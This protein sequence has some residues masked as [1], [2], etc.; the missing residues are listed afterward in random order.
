M[1]KR[2]IPGASDAGVYNPDRENSSKRQGEGIPGLMPGTMTK[3]D[4]NV[5]VEVLRDWLREQ[6]STGT[7]RKE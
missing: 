6:R 3:E 4:K 7:G 1:E 2:Y 5:F